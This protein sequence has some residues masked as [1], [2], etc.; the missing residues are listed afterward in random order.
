VRDLARHEA[1]PKGMS[2]RSGKTSG[3]VAAA[4]QGIE[5]SLVSAMFAPNNRQG[6]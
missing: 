6:T 4:L 5:F 2:Q 1:Y 3:I